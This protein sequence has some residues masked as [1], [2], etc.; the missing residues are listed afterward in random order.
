MSDLENTSEAAPPEE[1]V[2]ALAEPTAEFVRHAIRELGWDDRFA[3]VQMQA[4]HGNTTHIFYNLPAVVGY[5]TGGHWNTP[6]LVRGNKKGTV[7]WMDLRKFAA[8][9]RDA[10]RDVEL[11]DAI[12]SRLVDG[13]TFYNQLQATQ[14]LVIHRMQQYSA[15]LEAAEAA[16]KAQ[17]SE[18][19]DAEQ[20][21]DA[22]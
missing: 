6:L 2:I 14:Q 5:L 15:V 20:V 16:E 1:A 11:A 17:A 12:D 13:D 4:S 10:V 19:Q 8:W 22:G 9:L 18:S 7:N 21:P 3:A